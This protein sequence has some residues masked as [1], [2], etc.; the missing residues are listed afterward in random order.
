MHEA[1]LKDEREWAEW[2]AAGYY[3][4]HSLP[5]PEILLIRDPNAG[6]QMDGGGNAQPQDGSAVR[7]DGVI[8]DEPILVGH[9]IRCSQAVSR[10]SQIIYVDDM[11]GIVPGMR[12]MLGARPTKEIIKGR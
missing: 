11:R 9:T 1:S 4:H 7:S 8:V 12:F 10:A 3:E 6:A 5:V 2:Y